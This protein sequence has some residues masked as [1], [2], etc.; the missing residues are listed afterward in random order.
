MSYL[1]AAKRTMAFSEYTKKFCEVG[2]AFMSL[3]ALKDTRSA[4]VKNV[5]YKQSSESKHLKLYRELL[6]NFTKDEWEVISAAM[7]V[8]H[9]L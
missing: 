9:V 7:K 3:L 1:S 6:S 2:N 4:S 5:V 8:C